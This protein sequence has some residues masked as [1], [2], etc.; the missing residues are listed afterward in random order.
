MDDSGILRCQD[1][2]RII[3][4]NLE[5]IDAHIY[6]DI[7]K[8]VV[9]EPYNWTGSRPSTELESLDS[10]EAK[11]LFYLAARRAGE[12]D[13][14]PLAQH[15]PLAKEALEFWHEYWRRSFSSRGLTEEVLKEALRVFESL[16]GLGL[17]APLWPRINNMADDLVCQLIEGAVEGRTPFTSEQILRA[18]RVR[19]LAYELIPNL[20]PVTLL[21]LRLPIVDPARKTI[22]LGEVQRPMTAFKLHRSW[23][24]WVEHRC[25]PADEGFDF[26]SQIW[27]EIG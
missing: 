21:T 11:L 19:H 27:P 18:L 7:E 24:W 1:I 12:D 13:H 26:Y 22:Y 2:D 9:S 3:W 14:E 17:Y 5:R 15:R 23:Y 4:N 16:H 20:T 8:A 6:A 10:H 25:A